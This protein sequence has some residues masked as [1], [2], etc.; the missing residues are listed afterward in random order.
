LVE[1]FKDKALALPPLNTTL[2]RRMMETTRIYKALKGVRGRKPVDLAALEKLMVGFSQLVAEQRWIKEIDINPLFA[3]GDDLVALDARVILH[4]P[5]TAEDQLPKLSICPY[6]TQYVGAWKMK[7]A[8]KVT[9]RP[10]RPE[11][12]PLMVKFHEG[13]SER[14]VYQRYFSPLKLSERVAHTRLVRTCFNDYDCEIALVAERKEA[15]GKSQIVGIARLSKVHGSNAG[16][17]A[18][19]VT[20]ASQHKGLGTELTKRLVQVAKDEKLGRL[21]AYTLG[22]NKD[23]QQMCKKIG[24]K[25]RTPATECECVIEMDL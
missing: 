5:K 13:L 3:S 15:K 1:I 11:D 17:F 14:S 10:I 18:V 24:F 4:D 16:E 25:I 21:V 7:D 22:E 19:V 8:T 2:A 9:I 20:D 12:E 23:M 6:P